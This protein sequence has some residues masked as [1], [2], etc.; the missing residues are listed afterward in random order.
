MK[1]LSL[2]LAVLFVLCM[3]VSG[4]AAISVPSG[5][6]SMNVVVEIGGSR[7]AYLVL[8]DVSADT[9]I[10]ASGEK[11]G[12]ISFGGSGATYVAHPSLAGILPVK[13]YV[14]SDAQLGS[15]ETVILADGSEIARL[16]VITTLQQDAIKA[17]QENVRTL[18]GLADVNARID[19]LGS[20]LTEINNKVN[21]TES[22]IQVLAESQKNLDAVKEETKGLAASIEDLKTKSQAGNMVTGMVLEGVSMSFAI[23]FVIGAIIML[24]FS[25][26]SKLKLPRRA[27]L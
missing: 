6:R 21:S 7:E 20:R 1:A 12:W 18:Q 14:P 8:Q 23:G 16:T 13:I 22:S 19:L 11:A 2:A 5:Q 4:V 27:S 26:R 15:Y 17:L 24:L 3:I 25:N 9:S 10:T